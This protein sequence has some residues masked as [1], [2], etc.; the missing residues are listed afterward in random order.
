MLFFGYVFAV[1]RVIGKHRVFVCVKKAVSSNNYMLLGF[2]VNRIN[3]RVR[4]AS[5]NKMAIIN[6]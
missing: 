5:N 1:N 4:I 6:L 2:G 3:Y